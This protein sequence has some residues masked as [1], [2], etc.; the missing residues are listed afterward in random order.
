MIFEQIATGGCQSYLVGCEDT[1]IAALIDPEIRQ[2]DHYLALATRAGVRIHY[3]ID[4]HT[5]A[6]HF[7]A[8]KQLGERLKVPVVMHHES[9]APFAGLRLDDGEMLALGKLR[10]HAL[11]TP[12]HTR[13]SMCLVLDDRV[14]TGDTLLIGG[15]GRTDLPSGDPDQLYESLFDKLLKLDPALAVYPA[16]DYKGRSHTTIGAELEANPRLQKHE[17]AEFTDMMRHLNLTAPDHITEAL[18]TNMSGGKTVTQLLAEAGAMVPFMA[19]GELN[20]RT[21]ARPNDLIVL[22]V[23]EK[24]AYDA[25]HIPG[26]RHLP[27]GQLELRVNEDL[28]DPTLRI[29]VCCEFG[30]ISTL[31]AATLRQLGFMRAAALDGGV[32]AWREGGFPV[33]RL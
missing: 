18:R 16:H 15:T 25:G 3:V 19:L 12:G 27:R 11:H 31:A 17:R 20:T 14:F 5:H 9:P 8:A 24:G 28:P 2:I 32:K 10:L 6:D 33:E 29:V 13:D 7:S 21:A 23:R 26:A 22:D 1:R 30:K 4:T